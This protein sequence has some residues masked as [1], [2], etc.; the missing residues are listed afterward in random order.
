MGACQTFGG[1]VFKGSRA[2][3]P[4]GRHVAFRVVH[5]SWGGGVAERRHSFRCARVIVVRWTCQ[6]L[7]TC[8]VTRITEH[9][10]WRRGRCLKKSLAS[11][12]HSSPTRERGPTGIPC[13][14]V[15]GAW[16]LASRAGSCEITHFHGLRC[17]LR[18]PPQLQ[19]SK[20]PSGSQQ[21]DVYREPKSHNAR[22]LH[23][24][25]THKQ[26]TPLEGELLPGTAKPKSFT[27]QSGGASKKGQASRGETLQSQAQTTE[28]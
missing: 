19:G 12:R 18:W 23:S 11:A 27:T 8:I 10:I 16:L 4:A 1:F 15:L 2:S 25:A 26:G 6:S 13:H 14:V 9:R 21:P 5:K 7:P 22:A 28:A 3:P 20:R 17:L 24:P